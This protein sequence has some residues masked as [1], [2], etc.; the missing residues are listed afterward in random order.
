MTSMIDPQLR[1]LHEP[2]WSQPGDL[3][4]VHRRRVNAK[5]AHVLYAVRR[6]N[7]ELASLGL[8]I[9]FRVLAEDYLS[10]SPTP[11]EQP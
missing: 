3:R 4:I 6:A 9:A 10:D 8:E 2:S 7:K 1:R 11:T 5:P